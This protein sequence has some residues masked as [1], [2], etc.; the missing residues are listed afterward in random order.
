MSINLKTIRQLKYT[1]TSLCMIV[2]DFLIYYLTYWFEQKKDKLI[3][4]TPLEIACYVVGLMTMGLLY[5]I[6]ECF[7]FGSIKSV[8]F[9]FPKLLFLFIALAVMKLY[10]Y[11]YSTR[12]RYK[13]IVTEIPV[14]FSIS[15]DTGAV[16]CIGIVFLTTLSP[17][18]VSTIL[19]PFGG[20][21]LTNK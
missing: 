11:V 3:W 18:I 4:S 13:I 20:H 7:E 16:I 19:I 6:N 8:Q 5:S 2:L 14:E 1:F 15:D 21:T 17:F 10:D 12:N 9:H